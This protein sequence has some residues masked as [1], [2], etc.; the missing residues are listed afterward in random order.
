M[1]DAIRGSRALLE[2]ENRYVTNFLSM[3]L[4]QVAR[5]DNNLQHCQNRREQVEN[6]TF[7]DMASACVELFQSWREQTVKLH[8]SQNRREQIPNCC[9]FRYGKSRR[10]I[11]I[12]EVWELTCV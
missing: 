3:M 6:A 12:F 10:W 7:L 5:A 2:A 8:F 4:F 1:G 11:C 9:L